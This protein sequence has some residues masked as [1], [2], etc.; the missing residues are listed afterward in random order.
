MVLN[1]LLNLIKKY[2]LDFHHLVL[3]TYELFNI[4]NEIFKT[5]EIRKNNI[6]VHMVK[7]ECIKA[8]EA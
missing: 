1:N 2:V 3:I 6:D 8:D 5:T 4:R 7:V